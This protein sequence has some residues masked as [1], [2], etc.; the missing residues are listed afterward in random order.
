MGADR[1]GGYPGTPDSATHYV[2]CAP[3]APA[4]LAF[5][6][7]ASLASG[8]LVALAA[9]IARG[10]RRRGVPADVGARREGRRLA[11]FAARNAAK[12]I[13]DTWR[14]P[15]RS[16]WARSRAGCAAIAAGRR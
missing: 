3:A 14:D 13:M 12:A 2:A 15:R 10:E 9:E 1:S 8:R 16:P 5:S 6:G 11:G 4:H 7:V